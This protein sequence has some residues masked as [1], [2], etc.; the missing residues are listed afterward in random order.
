MP[1]HRASVVTYWLGYFSPPEA[2]FFCAVAASRC[3]SDI[4]H[5]MAQ[6]D[7]ATAQNNPGKMDPYH[8]RLVLE[9]LADS[10]DPDPVL[11]TL[12]AKGMAVLSLRHRVDG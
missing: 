11:A 8:R 2:G 12:Q 9:R 5:R 6:R 10:A 7:A 3:L 1:A 4:P